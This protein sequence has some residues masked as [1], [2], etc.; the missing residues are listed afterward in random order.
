MLSTYKRRH[1][2]SLRAFINPL[3]LMMSRTRVKA[4]LT[5]RHAEHRRPRGAV[6]YAVNHS[7]SLDVP[8]ACRAAGRHSWV[9]VGKQRLYLS[10]RLFFCLNGTIWVDRKDKR[11]MQK[12]KDRIL[13]HMEKGHSLIFFPEGTWNLTENLLMLPMKWG[14]IE[15]AQKAKVPIVPMILEYSED[16]MGCTAWIGEQMSVKGLS[17]ADGITQLRDKMAEMRWQMWEEKGLYSRA[18]MDSETERQKLFQAVKDYPPMDWEY[19]ESIIYSLKGN[20]NY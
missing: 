16:K 2:A 14:I 17:L 9:L 18:E 13:R 11:D 10:D 7:N 5:L 20:L 15:L 1:P 6:I 19:E 8:L 12:A 4:K 3:V